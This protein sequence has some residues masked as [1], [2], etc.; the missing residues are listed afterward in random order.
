MKAIR[1]HAFGG[2]EVLRC[3][4]VEAPV[5]GAGEVLVRVKAAGVNPSDTY[6]RSGASLVK[7]PLPYTPGSDAAGVVEAVGAGVTHVKRNDRVYTA[8]SLSGTYAE[9]T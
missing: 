4:D 9:L 7:P 1:V 3:E 2:P 6:T 5:P 8:R